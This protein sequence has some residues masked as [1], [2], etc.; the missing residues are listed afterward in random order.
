LKT[1][2]V[3]I[4]KGQRILESATNPN[5]FNY[6]SYQNIQNMAVTEKWHLM[7]HFSIH[8]AFVDA[9]FS[10]VLF[11]FQDPRNVVAK[12]PGLLESTALVFNREN[13]DPLLEE[14]LKCNNKFTLTKRPGSTPAFCKSRDPGRV[15]RRLRRIYILV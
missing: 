11:G 8:T 1:V 12:Y 7:N 5:H 4:D 14:L 2:K 3:A 15:R 13:T 9:L 10:N 6:E